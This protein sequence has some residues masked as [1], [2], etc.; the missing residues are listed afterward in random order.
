MDRLRQMVANISKQFGPLR[1]THKLLMA[2]VVV[3]ALMTLF[4]VSQYAGSSDLREVLPGMPV[5]DQQRAVALLTNLA[6]DGKMQDGKLMVP[7]ASEMKARAVL[8]QSGEVGDDKAI[9][10]QNILQKQSWTNSRQQN[11]RLYAVAL[12]NE[13]ARTIASMTG[14]KSSQVFLD[15]PEPNGLGGR[16]KKPTASVTVE[17][18]TGQPVTQAMADAVAG[19]MAGALAGLELDAIRIIDSS[20]RQLRARSEGDQM[21]ATYM[22]H[23]TRVETKVRQTVLDLLEYIPGVV[24]AVTAQVD[25]TRVTSQETSFAPENKGT[26]SLDKE[27]TKITN[28]SSE[29]SPAAIPGVE[30]NQTADITRLGSGVGGIMTRNEETTLKSENHVGSKTQNTLDPK[31]YPTL[32][33]VSVNVPRSFVASLIRTAEPQGGGGVSGTDEKAAGPTDQQVQEKFTTAVRP[34]I[35]ESLVPQVRALMVQS[36]RIATAEEIKKLASEMISVAMIPLAVSYTH[37]TLPTNREV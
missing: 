6:I 29:A 13:L 8:L 14:V 33:A 3:I 34:V 10:F 25:V 2:S 9:L 28:D 22:E 19:L 15:I 16:V 37:L 21:P 32:V 27:R 23:A 17:T 12:Q 11:D 24:V 18:D 4:V 35:I 5:E 26:V 7:A 36:G 30:A 20:G 31:G 1:A